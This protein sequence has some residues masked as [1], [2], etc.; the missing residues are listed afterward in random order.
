MYAN[1]RYP[2]PPYL[3]LC[4]VAIMP[5][6]SSAT[7]F[8]V[9]D[10]TSAKESP[11]KSKIGE[12]FKTHSSPLS[13]PSVIGQGGEEGR[14]KRERKRRAG[15]VRRTHIRLFFAVFQVPGMT[16]TPQPSLTR[17]YSSELAKEL[18][19]DLLF[20]ANP[21]LP[22]LHSCWRHNCRPSQCSQCATRAYAAGAR[23]LFTVYQCF[24]RG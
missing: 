11:Q 20:W 8:Q 4:L 24:A 22:W 10:R 18:H 23:S 7:H 21:G 17:R 14:R 1:F 9:F 5:S 2:L 19:G 16:S 3:L 15:R 6:A 12:R 13:R